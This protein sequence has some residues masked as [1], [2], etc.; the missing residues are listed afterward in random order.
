MMLF[1]KVGLS[2]TLKWVC[3]VMLPLKC[4]LGGKRWRW[5]TWHSMIQSRPVTP[6][7]RLQ[8]TEL[9]PYQRYPEL[10]FQLGNNYG[11]SVDNS[12]LFSGSWIH[13]MENIW[14]VKS[15][16]PILLGRED[17]NLH[18]MNYYVSSAPLTSNRINYYPGF[19][20]CALHSCWT[21]LFNS[22]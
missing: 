12:S 4:N 1:Q 2:V 22:I 20:E 7:T 3:Q 5:L 15:R 19:N 10:T 14:I 9:K 17:V 11:F 13:S 18:Q 8:D 21:N 16:I 6:S